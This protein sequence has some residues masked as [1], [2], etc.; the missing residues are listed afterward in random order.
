[1][2]QSVLRHLLILSAWPAIVGVWVDTDAASGCK[3]TYNLYILWIHQ[4]NKILHYLV[5][6]VLVKITMIAEAEEVKLQTLRLHHPLVGEI[7]DA[8]L[9]EVR[10]TRDGTQTREFRA[11]EPHPIVIVGMLVHKCLKHLGGIIALILSLTSKGRQPFLF[12]FLHNSFS[13]E[14]RC[15]DMNKLR[16][17]VIDN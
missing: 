7:V 17:K 5:H 8:N 10:L 15:K 12:S 4:L 13:F 2:Q 9:G 14:I 6:A 1:M 3:Q 16:I 11:V